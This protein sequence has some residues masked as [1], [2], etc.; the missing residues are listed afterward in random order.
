M[1]WLINKILFHAYQIEAFGLSASIAE[2]IRNELTARGAG[3]SAL[4]ATDDTS[5]YFEGYSS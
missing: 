4:D 1:T 2:R 3:V 5:A